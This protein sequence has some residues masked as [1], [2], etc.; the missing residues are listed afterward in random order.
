MFEGSGKDNAVGHRK[1]LTLQF[2][3]PRKN[4]PTIGDRLGYRQETGLKPVPQIALKPLFQTGAALSGGLA[5][6]SFAE[7]PPCDN[8]GKKGS[9]IGGFDPL[10]DSRFWWL[11]PA[12][13]GKNIGIDQITVQRSTGRP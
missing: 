10:F 7:F 11:T 8:T 3:L 12:K 6:N 4:P 2:G 1:C 5:L 9:R 13:L